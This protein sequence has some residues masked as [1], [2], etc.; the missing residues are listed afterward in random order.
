[1]AGGAA[2]NAHGV[3]DR[4]TE[5]LDLFSPEQ[6]EVAASTEALIAALEAAV[7]SVEVVRRSR[8]FARLHVRDDSERTLVDLRYDHRFRATV[9]T[10]LGPTLSVEEL[11]A[12]KVLALFGRAEARDLVDVEA[13]ARGLG[14]E[15]LL[16]LAAA[17]DLGFDVHVFAQMLARTERIPDVEFGADAAT[18]DTLR[19]FA[20]S[21]RVAIGTGLLSGGTEAAGEQS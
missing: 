21:W 6:E 20:R 16:Q 4:P 3:V 7:L 2:L 17:K 11:A 1:M 15:T 8:T 14:R 5:D 12:D 9:Q 18:V 19:E 10:V 13:L